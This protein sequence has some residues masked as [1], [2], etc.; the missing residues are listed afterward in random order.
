MLTAFAA[1]GTK[2]SKEERVTVVIESKKHPPLVADFSTKNM[3]SYCVFIAANL[4]INVIADFKGRKAM[5]YYNSQDYTQY[6][7]GMKIIPLG[8]SELKKIIQVN[9]TYKELYLIFEKAF[10][11]ELKPHVWY[12][13]CIKKSI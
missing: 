13:D 2:A 5:F 3:N 7:E 8:I 12:E 6:I 11:S 9:K 4:N 1:N 10:N